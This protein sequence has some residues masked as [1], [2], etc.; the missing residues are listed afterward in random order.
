MQQQKYL[1]YCTNCRPSS[2][3]G[4]EAEAESSNSSGQKA[5][6]QDGPPSKKTRLEKIPDK[7]PEEETQTNI[8][9][10]TEEEETNTNTSTS[11]NTVSCEE[12][13]SM[14]ETRSDLLSYC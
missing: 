2:S 14:C 9:Y 3:T 12:D 4:T 13:D 8:S 10:N 5:R 11:Y 6:S 7:T 1:F